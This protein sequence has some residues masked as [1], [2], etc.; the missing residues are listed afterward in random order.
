MESG[1]ILSALTILNICAQ[2]RPQ[3]LLD[4]CV[5]PGVL[6]LNTHIARYFLTIG[7]RC[8][9]TVLVYYHPFHVSMLGFKQYF[10]PFLGTETHIVV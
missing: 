3:T 6:G 1:N 4:R 5:S 2:S 8:I 7:R 10:S 9:Y